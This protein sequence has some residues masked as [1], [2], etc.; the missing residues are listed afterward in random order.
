MQGTSITGESSLGKVQAEP[1]VVVSSSSVTKEGETPGKPVASSRKTAKKSKVKTEDDDVRP[2]PE[3]LGEMDLDDNR[4]N[5]AEMD[6]PGGPVSS[7]RKHDRNIRGWKKIELWMEDEARDEFTT[8]T[9]DIV[10]ASQNTHQQDV[11][12][13]TEDE[14]TQDTIALTPNKMLIDSDGDSPMRA[15]IA[16]QRRQKRRRRKILGKTEEQ[17]EEL[18]LEEADR[19]LLQT[20]FLDEDEFEVSVLCDLSKIVARGEAILASASI[21]AAAASRCQGG[22]R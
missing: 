15:T 13:K 19:R 2:L 16:A 18:A 3:S 5:L 4:V 11:I 14:V 17:Q 12:V 21:D 1:G 20:T 9:D 6:L 22:S 10:P 8:E 7:H